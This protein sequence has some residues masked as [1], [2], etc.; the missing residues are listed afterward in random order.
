LARILMAGRGVAADPVQAARWHLLASD[1]GIT[2]PV[3]D[4][5]VAGLSE[6]QRKAAANAAARGPTG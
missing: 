6:D 1:A 5:F 2:D 3:L 4:E